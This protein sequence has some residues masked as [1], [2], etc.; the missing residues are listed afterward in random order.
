[1]SAYNVEKVMI[2]IFSSVTISTDDY[3]TVCIGYIIPINMEVHRR[4]KNAT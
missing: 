3:K 4:G 2:D 1:M